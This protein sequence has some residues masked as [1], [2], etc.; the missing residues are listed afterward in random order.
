MSCKCAKRTDE[1]HGWVCS[2]T[3]S[4]CI[5]FIPDSKQCAEDYGE[6]PDVKEDEREGQ[7]MKKWC[8]TCDG[9]GELDN[10][11]RLEQDT[12]L[13]PDC[14][15]KGYTENE[16]IKNEVNSEIVKINEFAKE[17]HQN[18]VEHGW[19][20]TNRSFGEIIALCHSE[21]SEA[22]EEHRNGQPNLY[23]VLHEPGTIMRHQK[24]TTTDPENFRGLKPEGI[25]TELADCIIRIL[26]YCAYDG[27]DIEQAIQLKH[28]YNKTRPYR[29]GGKRI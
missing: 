15:G 3:E 26:D 8:D 29:H 16:T 19:W 17:V 7:I 4:A 25:A 9:T 1:Y 28:E 2:I 23:V 20:D 13:C 21:L 5:Y 22:L 27:I 18:A 24:S 14:N 6:G 12:K 11:T 10:S